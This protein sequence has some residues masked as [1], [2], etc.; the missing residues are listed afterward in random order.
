MILV[1]MKVQIIMVWIN[2]NM[3][4]LRSAGIIDLYII[5]ALDCIMYVAN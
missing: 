1:G 4:F 5:M 2:E 3:P